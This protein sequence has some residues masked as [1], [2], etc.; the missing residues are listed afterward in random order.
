MVVVS[1]GHTVSTVDIDISRQMKLSTSIS[2]GG[3]VEGSSI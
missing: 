1:E 2:R 3:K